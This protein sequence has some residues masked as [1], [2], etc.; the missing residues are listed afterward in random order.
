MFDGMQRRIVSMWFPRL[1]SDRALRLCPI[2][3]PFAISHRLNGADYIY[4]VNA[5]AEGQGVYRGMA[6][7]EARAFCPGL[8]MQPQDRR[9]DSRFLMGLRRWAL[10]YCP[11]VGV[12]PPDGLVLDISGSARLLGPEPALLADMQ[13][14]LDR[15]GLEVRLGVAGSAA[16]AWALAH[17]RPG[18]ALP[19]QS[20]D[21][22]H[23]LPV[24]ALRLDEPCVTA[25]QRLGLHTIGALA[26]AARAPLARRFGQGL[27]T[28]LDQALEIAPEPITPLAEPPHF[29]VRLTF[30]DPIGLLDDVMAGLDRLLRALCLKLKAHE[31]GARALCL[32]LRRVDRHSQMLPLR[33]AAAMRDPDRISPL[34]L[35]VVQNADAGFGIDQLRLEATLIEPL[36]LQ[37]IGAG[38]EARDQLDNLLTR[39]GARVGLENVFRFQSVD[40][41]LPEQSFCLLP[42]TTA[43]AQVWTNSDMLAARRRPRPLRIFPPEAIVGSGARPPAQFRWRGMRL[44]AGYVSGPERIAPQWWHRA[45]GWQGGLRDYW[46]VET[47]QGRRLWLFYTPQSPGWYVQGEFL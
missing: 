19:G 38:A 10:R 43:P 8:R 4:D 33:L 45:D 6:A 40:S 29:G 24:A 17:H 28:R 3:G 14:R 18:I 41:H 23:A 39:I 46:R 44:D 5:L 36:P 26:A 35:P 9:L 25:L 1:A 31:A 7:S 13:A 34:F 30:P 2:D 12:E 32:T 37:Q 21:R 22:L 20:Q 11:W 47:R 27:L 16:A 15:S 42:I